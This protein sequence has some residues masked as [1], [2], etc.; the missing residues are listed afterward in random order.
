[1]YLHERFMFEHQQALLREME[2]RRLLARLPRHQFQLVRRLA[3]SIGEL[4]MGCGAS[5]KRFEP[6]EELVAC[7]G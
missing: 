7:D 2:Q 5:L 6:S 4:L 1:M 3:A